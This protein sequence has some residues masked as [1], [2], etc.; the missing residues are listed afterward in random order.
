MYEILLL[1]KKERINQSILF[2]F[3]NG[4]NM[5]LTD[6][7]KNICLRKI[8]LSVERISVDKVIENL[9]ISVYTVIENLVEHGRQMSAM[10][11]Q[12]F[13]DF[14]LSAMLLHQ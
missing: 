14:I 7:R 2:A 3:R 11:H 1:W 10:F 5:E 12:I 9:R 13:N 8:K 4:Y 6:L